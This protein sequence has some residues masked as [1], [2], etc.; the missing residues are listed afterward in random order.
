MTTP[1]SS[2]PKQNTKK[3]T[4]S[5][6]KPNSAEKSRQKVDTKN[7]S[8]TDLQALKA[9][10]P[11]MYYSIP[12]VWEAEIFLQDFDVSKLNQPTRRIHNATGEQGTDSTEVSRR[13]RISFECHPDMIMETGFGGVDIGDDNQM[14]L[15]IE[16]VMDSFTK[17]ST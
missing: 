2:S 15:D 10:D 1:S 12:Q 4:I 14:D 3:I 5:T 16:A 13:S 6:F 7:L 11:F 8:L 9:N 17:L